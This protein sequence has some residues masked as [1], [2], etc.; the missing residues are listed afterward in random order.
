MSLKSG[1]HSRTELLLAPGR[2]P[3]APDSLSDL[4]AQIMVIAPARRRLGM[5]HPG[6]RG[7]VTG[8]V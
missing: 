1:V 5:V 8:N 7:G 6:R 3:E 4:A 2:R